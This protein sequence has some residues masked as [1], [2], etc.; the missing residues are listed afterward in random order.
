MITTLIGW[1]V[2]AFFTYFAGTRLFRETKT[3]IDRTERKT[4]IRAMGF[5][6]APGV[7]RIL[8]MIPGFWNDRP[9]GCNSLDDCCRHDRRKTSIKL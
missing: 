2:W 1:Y 3:E 9:G 4:V 8:G 5:A 7:A 6:S